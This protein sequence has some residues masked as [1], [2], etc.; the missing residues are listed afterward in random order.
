MGWNEGCARCEEVAADPRTPTFALSCSRVCA[1]PPRFDEITSALLLGEPSCKNATQV[2]LSQHF[3]R[4]SPAPNCL[5][6]RATSRSLPTRAL[7]TP[8]TG[9][10]LL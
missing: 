4:A 6:Q 2:P 5:S 3:T 8:F 10:S 9:V 1:S 7:L